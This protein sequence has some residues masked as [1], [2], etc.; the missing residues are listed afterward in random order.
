MSYF[1]KN[2][3]PIYP[4]NTFRKSSM[5]TKNARW[6]SPLPG[7]RADGDAIPRASYRAAQ[8]ARF[9]LLKNRLLGEL[10]AQANDPQRVLPLRRAANEAEALAWL[11]P[12]PELIFPVLLEEKA[13]ATVRQTERQARMR[14]TGGSWSDW[15]AT[16]E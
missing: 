15:F 10:M 5:R 14:R 11:T 16:A 3:F 2:V 7:F 1:S 13:A 8:D 6:A 9:L 4:S 12:F